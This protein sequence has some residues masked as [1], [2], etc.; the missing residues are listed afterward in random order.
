MSRN[1]DVVAVAL[2][3]GGIGLY[4]CGRNFLINAINAHRMGIMGASHVIVVPVPPPPP[5][6]D[7]PVRF[8]RN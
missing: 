7:P 8:M 4:A 5:V 3:L 6:P 1:V 2:L